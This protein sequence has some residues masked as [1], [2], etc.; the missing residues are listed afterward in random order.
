MSLLLQ[1]WWPTVGLRDPEAFSCPMLMCVQE[2]GWG[3]QVWLRG[4]DPGSTPAAF[5]AE[6]P[7]PAKL[8]G[9]TGLGRESHWVGLGGRGWTPPKLALLHPSRGHI[10]PRSW[11]GSSSA[12]S[13]SVDT[14]R[15][16]F[17]F[18]RGDV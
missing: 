7:V 9:S 4:E 11:S 12:Q 16:Y 5:Q 8:I 3:D 1:P 14:Q 2:V 10:C 13:D 17:P 18:T 6:G 15:L